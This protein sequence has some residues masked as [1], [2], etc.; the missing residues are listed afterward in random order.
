MVK[1]LITRNIPVDLLTTNHYIFGQIKV[2]NTGM[3]GALSDT[4]T[5]HLEILDASISRIVKPD[6]VIN[7]APILWIV[8]Q[9][10]VAACLSKKE[11]VGSP[12]LM[13]GGYA[14]LTQ[15]PMQIATPN[16]EVQGTL[17]W[18]GRFEFSVIMGDGTSPFLVL[19]DAVLSAPLF[20][21]LQIQSPVILLNRT[22]VNLLSSV[23]KTGQEG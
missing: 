9:Q 1:P 18:S 20:P 4:N 7:Y 22:F 3:I 23:K 2:A 10:L 17:E 15:Y 12:A 16:Y 14:H 21:A 13:R 19:Y 8:K 5:S 11:Y 6:K